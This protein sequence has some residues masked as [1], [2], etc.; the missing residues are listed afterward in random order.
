MSLPALAADTLPSPRRPSPA[1]AGPREYEPALGHLTHVA[2][3]HPLAGAPHG[4]L[5]LRVRTLHLRLGMEGMLVL[6]DLAVVALEFASLEPQAL[7]ELEQ[8]GSVSA[9]VSLCKS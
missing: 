5:T 3:L 1:L 8:V 4:A 6:F 2:T 9:T 7:T